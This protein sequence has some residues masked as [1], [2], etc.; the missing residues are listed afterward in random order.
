MQNV[1]FDALTTTMVVILAICGAVNV[2]GSTVKLIKEAIK[3]KADT[4][5]DIADRLEES[6]ARLDAHD[7]AIAALKDGQKHMCE[8]VVALLNHELHNGNSTEMQ[9]ASDEIT[10]WMIR[11]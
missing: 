2:I 7:K 6:E 4:F 8:G 3:P 5:T 1:T 9:K 11:K 10:A